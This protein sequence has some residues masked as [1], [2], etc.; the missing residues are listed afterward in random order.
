MR[1]Y[2][3][4]PVP[5]GVRF[6]NNSENPIPAG[7]ILKIVKPPPSAITATQPDPYSDGQITIRNNIVTLVGGQWP[8]W[9]GDATLVIVNADQTST[10]YVVAARQTNTTLR[11]IAPNILSG[12]NYTLNPPGLNTYSTGTVKI[13]SGVVTLRFAVWPWWA[14][15]GNLL[16]GTDSYQVKTRDSDTQIR[17]NDPTV[18]ADSGTEYRLV[19]P[20]TTPYLSGGITDGVWGGLH[21]VNGD[22]EVSSND[23]GVAFPFGYPGLMVAYERENPVSPRVDL[24]EPK[25]GELWGIKR[26]SAVIH[27]DEPG[28]MICGDPVEGRVPVWPITM[29]PGLG[30]RV[31]P[32]PEGSANNELWEKGKIADVRYHT[33]NNYIDEQTGDLRQVSIGDEPEWEDQILKVF[34]RLGDIVAPQLNEQNE[35]ES[36]RWVHIGLIGGFEGWQTLIAEC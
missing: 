25:F 31:L 10:T 36:G 1:E 15:D 9:A 23:K 26:D 13:V 2:N 33:G 32:K 14:A 16:I 12:V 22:V 4:Y 18:N 24:P 20:D 6:V 5:Q 27:R 35:S 29:L 7:G 21:M 8:S 19:P 17:L 3:P 28:F 11:V 34:V 30:G